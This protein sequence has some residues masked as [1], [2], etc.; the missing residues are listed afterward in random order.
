VR[1]VVVAHL[2]ALAVAQLAELAVDQP[3]SLER[4]RDPPAQLPR[5]F[6]AVPLPQRGDPLEQ[7]PVD[8]DVQPDRGEQALDAVGVLG[9]L[10][11]EL[12]A[13]A[14]WLAT[15]LIL[16]RGDVYDRPDLALAA[17]RAMPST[18]PSS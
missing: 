1:H 3:P 17:P 6:R 15:V 12:V 16:G 18:S 14:V 9:P 2:A 13:V 5:H 8:A 4:S 10:A 11:D 7:P